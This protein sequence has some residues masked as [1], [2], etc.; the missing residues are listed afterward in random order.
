MFPTNHNNHNTINHAGA[1]ARERDDASMEESHTAF[2]LFPLCFGLLFSSVAS[3]RRSYPHVVPRMGRIRSGRSITAPTAAA[4]SIRRR[5]RFAMPPSTGMRSTLDRTTRL[6]ATPT[7]QLNYS[8]A[9]GDWDRSI[10]SDARTRGLGYIQPSSL[11][12]G[13]T[14][15]GS[16]HHQQA[17]AA[18]APAEP[19]RTMPYPLTTRGGSSKMITIAAATALVACCC[20]G[21]AYYFYAL[22]AKKPRRLSKAEKR[23]VKYEKA[24]QVRT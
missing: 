24:K 10:E 22:P 16:G 1:P 12:A 6:T 15:D 14:D 21:L 5:P 11:P 23:A 2:T 8:P 13:T 3:D 19:S 9:G 7:P 17:A 4:R 20:A 18:T